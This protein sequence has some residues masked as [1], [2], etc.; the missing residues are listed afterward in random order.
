[1]GIKKVF[2]ILISGAGE[3]QDFGTTVVGTTIKL[4][5]LEKSEVKTCSNET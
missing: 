3:S 5:V 1:M 4:G 2:K